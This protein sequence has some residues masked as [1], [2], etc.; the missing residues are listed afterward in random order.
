MRL[1]CVGVVVEK[2]SM[3]KL[4]LNRGKLNSRYWGTKIWEV[5]EVFN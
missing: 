2:E 1:L 3:I 4:N 5:G